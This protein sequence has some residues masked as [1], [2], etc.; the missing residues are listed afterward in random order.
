MKVFNIN[1][2]LSFGTKR[3]YNSLI[4]SLYKNINNGR[5]SKDFLQRTDIIIP[6]IESKNNNYSIRLIH[7]LLYETKDTTAFE[8]YNKYLRKI[9]MK[10]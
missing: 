2:N 9:K 8:E 5:K 3:T 10:K 7:A 1:K 6:Y 4:N